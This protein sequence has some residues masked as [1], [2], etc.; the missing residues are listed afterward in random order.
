MVPKCIFPSGME[1]DMVKLWSKALVMIMNS[2]WII[3]TFPAH[4]RQPPSSQQYF[5][6][7]HFRTLYW[8]PHHLGHRHMGS[9]TGVWVTFSLRNAQRRSALMS[10]NPRPLNI[11]SREVSM[12]VE[13]RWKPPGVGTSR[14]RECRGRAKKA[15]GGGRETIAWHKAQ[16]WKLRLQNG[17][18][19]RKGS[20]G[21]WMPDSG[22]VTEQPW[23]ILYFLSA[24]L[25][26][27][28]YRV[29]VDCTEIPITEA[30]MH[31]SVPCK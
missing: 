19:L 14:D 10:T 24:Y 18:I 12:G 5:L 25:W 9:G 11:L 2:L 20:R 31:I 26:N 17:G 1:S 8:W 7:H 3:N 22:E 16:Q 21:P 4:S 30:G 23:L 13:A 29:P 28:K 15:V 6:T 27:C